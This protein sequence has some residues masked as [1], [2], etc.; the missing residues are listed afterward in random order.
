MNDVIKQK[1][2]NIS[3]CSGVY[4]MKDADGTVIYVGKAKN[5]K[6]RVSQYFQNTQKQAKVQAMVEHIADFEYFITL[7]EQDA[8]ALENNLIKKFQPFYNILLKDSKTF[9]YIKTNLKEDYPRFE[10]TRKIKKDGSKYFGPYIN[11]IAAKDVLNLLNLAFPV[12]KCKEKMG[13]KRARACLNYS[14]GLCKAP[15]MQYIDKSYYRKIVDEAVEFLKGNDNQVEAII[16]EKMQNYAQ[17]ENFEK[18]LEMREHL[19]IIKKLKAKVVANLPRDL[20]LDAFAYV[21]DGEAGAVCALTLRSGKILG[22]ED[23]SINDASISDSESLQNFIIA[24]YKNKQIPDQIIV[25]LPM[26]NMDD[27]NEYLQSSFQKSTFVSCPKIALKNQIIKMAEENAREHLFKRVREDKLKFKRTLGALINLKNVLNL[28][29]IPKRIECYDI[30][31]ISGTNKVASMVVFE[32]GEPARKMYRKFKIKTVEGSN[33]FA[34]LEETLTRRLNELDKQED[35]SFSKRPDLIMIDGG[36]GQLSTCYNVLQ[37]SKHSSIKMISLAEKF[38]EVYLPNKSTPLMLKRTGEELK[39][40]IRI[41]D[42][43]HRFAITFHRSLRGKSAIS[44]PLDDIKGVGRAK[45]IALYKQFKTLTNIKSASVE[46][47]AL[48]KGIHKDL[49]KTIFEY[50]HE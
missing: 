21:T 11:G 6:N 18:A 45:R 33:D 24:Y 27:F 25:N 7:S 32:N 49:A 50:F 14:I 9:A 17:A 15:C 39:L 20:S 28:P 3:E 10:I 43:A 36:K 26:D 47:L 44:D 42:E 1:L 4:I 2:N 40:L 35:E 31:N 41:R 19:K 30:S 13:K 12:R 34:S 48:V 29:Q 8:F 38:E 16:T 46:E 5:L 22:I 37:N 23:F